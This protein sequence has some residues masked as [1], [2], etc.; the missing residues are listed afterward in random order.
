MK[1]RLQLGAGHASRMSVGPK[2]PVIRRTDL[3]RVMAI[4]S[5]TKQQKN[6]TVELA[7]SSMATRRRNNF[8]FEPT[9]EVPAS[10]R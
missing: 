2:S 8:R 6:T 10:G 9:N 7:E 1:D 5:C 3:L 4:L